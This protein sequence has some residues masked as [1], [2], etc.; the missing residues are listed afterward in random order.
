MKR[1][2]PVIIHY[3]DN[4]RRRPPR[5]PPSR[6]S[7]AYRT[8]THMHNAYDTIRSTSPQY[9]FEIDNALY[10]LCAISS[11]YLS[12]SVLCAFGKGLKNGYNCSVQS[13]PILGQLILEDVV[14]CL[15]CFYSSESCDCCAPL[16]KV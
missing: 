14:I 9:I 16:V 8:R 6:L 7:R 10:A 3:D 2:Q 4:N 13:D 15:P 11:V 12:V 5:V 1:S